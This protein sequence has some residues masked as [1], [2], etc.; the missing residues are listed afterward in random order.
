MDGIKFLDDNDVKSLFE[1][2]DETSENQE[3]NGTKSNVT[4][5]SDEQ[6]ADIFN[7]NKVFDDDEEDE[8]DDNDDSEKEIE[9]KQEEN[10]TKEVKPET[11]S[12]ENGSN[13]DF[14]SIA[15]QFADEGIWELDDEE[16]K[17]ADGFKSLIKK[18][19]ENGIDEETRRVKEALELGINSQDVA[20]FEHTIKMLHSITNEDLYDEGDDGNQLRQKL[21]LQNFINEGMEEKE[22]VEKTKEIFK[23]GKDIDEAE[24]ALVANK[25]F[26]QQTY[27][28]LKASARK[29]KDEWDKSIQKQ[30]DDLKSSIMSNEKYLGEIDIDEKT[31]KTALA[32]LSEPRYKDKD[33]GQMLTAI[34]KYE[35]ENKTDFLKNLGL[36]FTLTDGFKNL[37]K[38]TTKAVN[39]RINKQI[40]DI[41]DV[42]KN[43]SGSDTS[44][45]MVTG[46]N[47]NRLNKFTFGI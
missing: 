44:L 30:T 21:I 5:I 14:S 34:Q 11:K 8:D 39:R 19:I 42:L 15:K 37:D 23:K 45:S 46:A 6:A 36:L 13:V 20:E 43:P 41:E 35:K 2:N 16:V 33:S 22:A 27:K 3:D 17:D 32:N 12:V 1:D 24:K 4:N 7:N 26:F 38:L 10:T 9:E 18:A 31:K 47:N 29:Q 25:K 28:D 40:S